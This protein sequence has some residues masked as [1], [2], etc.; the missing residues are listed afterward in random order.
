[1]IEAP[2]LDPLAAAAYAALFGVVVVATLRRQVDAIVALL[3]T[4]PLA[5]AH[6]VGATTLTFGKV[7]LIAVVAG[8]ILQRPSL[9]WLQRGVPRSLFLPIAA[10]VA[11]T[12]LSILVATDRAVALRETLKAVQYLLTFVVAAIAWHLDPDRARLRTT[13][14]AIASL[15]AVLALAQEFS[16]APSGIWYDGKAYPRIA[17]PLEGP[18]QLAG[19]LGV[20]LPFILVFALDAPSWPALV[21]AAVC[22]AALILTLSRAGLLAGLVAIATVLIARPALRRAASVALATGFVAGI[23][24][25]LGWR[26]AALDERFVSLAE[27]EQ[28]GGVGTRSILWRAAVELWRSH[29][30][31]GVGAGNYE[32]LLPGV[33]PP[34]IRTH[35]NSW[36]LQS[37]VEGG[38]PLLGATLW[39]VWASIA[40][41]R[42]VL[43]NDLC[44]AAFA[45]S[46]GFALHGVFD[47]LVFFPKIGLT[48][49]A[50]LG[51]AAAESLRID[52][53]A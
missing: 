28:S 35:T 45:A 31:L 6:A 3:A 26:V 44:L 38:L 50:L 48:W 12:A 19:Y 20:V 2:P 21:A 15:V 17:G 32:L 24:V 42:R 1:M 16:G 18:N 27:V 7:A 49:F 53:N 43:R 33:A 22:G 34:G 39:L 41:L 30:L 47:L 29:P 8:L 40:S 52:T 9:G 5:Y 13:I 23:G 36:Y 4:A 51:V 14:V 46:I 10:V 37:L 11:A 25:V